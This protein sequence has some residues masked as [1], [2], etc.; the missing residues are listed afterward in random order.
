[1]E[2]IKRVFRATAGWP[3]AA[4]DTG[5][6]VF[7]CVKTVAV[8]M[9]QPAVPNCLNVIAAE[10]V[11]LSPAEDVKVSCFLEGVVLIHFHQSA[12]AN[13]FPFYANLIRRRRRESEELSPRVSVAVWSGCTRVCWGMLLKFNVEPRTA[14][15]YVL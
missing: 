4:A 8:R 13:G 2:A 14:I 10:N 7:E 3:S 12:Q 15:I 5:M 1:M 11:R 9:H 6:S